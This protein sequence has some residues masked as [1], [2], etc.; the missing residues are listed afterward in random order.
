MTSVTTQT[1][2][3]YAGIGS[4]NTP[5]DICELMTQLGAKLA[6]KGAELRSGGADKADQSFER[7]CDKGNGT[8][9]IFYANDWIDKS[10]PTSRIIRW[11]YCD[12]NWAEA[13]AIASQHHPNWSNLKPYARKLHTRNC[14]QVLGWSL[15]LPVNFVLCWTPDGARTAAQTSQ[16]TGGTGQAI[17]VADSYGIKVYNL[18]VTEDLELARNWLNK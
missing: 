18:A 10:S 4:R 1:N 17:R 12:H 8:K 15:Q 16:K 2:K 3:I 7:G 9:Q 5:A 13:T 11:K 6:E 14:F